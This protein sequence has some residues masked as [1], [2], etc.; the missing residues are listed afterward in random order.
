[1]SQKTRKRPELRGVALPAAVHFDLG[2]GCDPE[3]LEQRERRAQA[4][5]YVSRDGR[6]QRSSPTDFLRKSDA[7]SARRRC[8][9]FNASGEI[10]E[11][12]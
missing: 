5:E 9:I 6:V 4:T 3:L 1:M 2:G 12:D 10:A 11:P 7:L 8:S